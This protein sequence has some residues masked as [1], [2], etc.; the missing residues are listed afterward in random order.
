MLAAILP[1]LERMAEG[2]RSCKEKDLNVAP[3]TIPNK[4]L[5]ATGLLPF[6]EEGALRD[7]VSDQLPPRMIG[8]SPELLPMITTLVF[9]DSAILRVAS[10]PF[11][12]R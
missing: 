7:E 12:L 8:R 4:Q 9:G 1:Y 6:L 10:I 3:N 11:H 2:T 5:F